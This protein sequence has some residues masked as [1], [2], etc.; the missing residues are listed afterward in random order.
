M[1][2]ASVQ[3]HLESLV[4]L[5]QHLHRNPELSHEEFET[6]KLLSAKLDRL[7]FDVHVRPEGT[8][9]YADLTPPDFD[10]ATDPTVAVRCDLDALAIHEQTDA[11]FQSDHP[12]KMHACGHDVHMTCAF[13]AGVAI[14]ELAADQP[15][16]GRLRLV[17]QHAEETVGGAQQM[18]EFG[19]LEDVDYVLALHVDPE[20]PVGSIGVREGAFTAAFDEFRFTIIG[21]A[22][23]GARP[24]HCV[25]PIFVLTQLAN[26]LYNAIGRSVDARDPMVFSIGIIKGG[27]VPNVIPDRAS[28]SG[29]I[30][31]I[32]GE[33]RALVEPLLVRVA[34]GICSSYGASYELDLRRG[35]PAIINDKAVT[36]LIAEVASDVVGA[37]NVHEIALPSMGSEDF[38]FFVENIPGAMFRLGAWTDGTPRYFLHS[39]KFLVDEG[40]IPVGATVLAKT[41]LRL[42]ERGKSA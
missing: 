5:R 28:M 30:R 1:I 36:K 32:S 14:A 12:N 21:E 38:S 16:P 35:A 15:P 18:I 23:H 4:E 31:T 3:S 20:L 17:Y 13:G 22:G 34:D 6:T 42:M 11:P 7:G 27:S 9:F 40:A 2:E 26:A 29:S 25:D 8:G 24:H 41:A 10:P 33:H 19:V 37:H 39:D